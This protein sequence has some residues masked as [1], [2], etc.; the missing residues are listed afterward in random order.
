LRYFAKNTLGMA[1]STPLVRM[2][3]FEGLVSFI[4]IA[5]SIGL[6]AYQTKSDAPTWM[7]VFW[8][9]LVLMVSSS[10][11]AMTKT[12]FPTDGENILNKYYGGVA[13]VNGGN[14]EFGMKPS[15]ATAI[16]YHMFCFFPVFPLSFI[17]EQMYR[18]GANT[19]FCPPPLYVWNTYNL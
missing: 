19:G 6:T 16:L 11:N 1:V 15:R 17:V 14:N 7:A 12:A 4:I 2:H 9:V 18:K 5:I 13:S 3:A 8:L 10:K